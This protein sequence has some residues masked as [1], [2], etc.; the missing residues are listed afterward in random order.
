MTDAT[1]DE[2]FEDHDDEEEGERL[3]ELGECAVELRDILLRETQLA[4]NGGLN[5]LSSAVRAKRE[6]WDKFQ[7]LSAKAA[8]DES[9]PGEADQQALKELIAAANENALIL[10]AVR[11]TIDDFAGRLKVALTSAA[12]PGLYGPKGKNLR[13]AMAARFDSKI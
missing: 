7:K 12:D 4:N 13:H 6:I 3:S 2:E 9:I 1:G 10:D 5:S 8:A 11:T